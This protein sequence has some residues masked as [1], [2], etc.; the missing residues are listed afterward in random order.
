MK[1]MSVFGDH[2]A[3]VTVVMEVGSPYWLI[4]AASMLHTDMMNV[5]GWARGLKIMS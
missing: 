5:A 4:K 2:H 1:V 3:L